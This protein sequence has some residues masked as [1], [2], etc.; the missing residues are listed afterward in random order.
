[1]IGARSKTRIDISA[2]GHQSEAGR[3]RFLV[4]PC[5]GNDVVPG[6]RAVRETCLRQHSLV[7]EHR[8]REGCDRPAVSFAMD[9]AGPHD[10]RCHWRSR[11]SNS[12][13]VPRNSRCRAMP[14]RPMRQPRYARQGRR[15]A[16]RQSVVKRN[17]ARTHCRPGLTARHRRKIQNW[18]AVLVAAELILHG[19]LAAEHANLRH[20][21]ELIVQPAVQAGCGTCGRRT[22]R[23]SGSKQ[24][25]SEGSVA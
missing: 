11:A 5:G 23:L 1:M 14:R 7:V 17:D 10:L 9:L 16:A 22:C 2:L 4:L 24:T 13:S 21:D 25:T 6:L 20:R 8:P 19:R 3:L 18:F 12:S 15:R